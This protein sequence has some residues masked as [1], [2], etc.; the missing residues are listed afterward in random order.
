MTLWSCTAVAEI[1]IDDGFDASGAGGLANWTEAVQGSGVIEHDGSIGSSTPGAAKLWTWGPSGSAIA[2]R[3]QDVL[4]ATRYLISARAMMAGEMVAH[5]SIG[6]T[7]VDGKGCM[8]GA[9]ILQ[10]TYGFVQ[11]LAIWHRVSEVTVPF[12]DPTPGDGLSL[13]LTLEHDRTGGAQ[14][15]ECLFDDFRLATDVI[16]VSHFD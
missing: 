7:L 4:E 9:P 12:S 6:A 8:N 1:L 5:C 3:C 16:L 11:P 15:A 14:P 2:W 10:D 13:V